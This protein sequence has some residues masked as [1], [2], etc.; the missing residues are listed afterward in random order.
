[1]YCDLNSVDL[2]F[3]RP[4]G[5]ERYVQTDHR[6]PEEIGEKEE[7]SII[8][9][10][11]RML[12][13]RWAAEA[14][15]TLCDVEYHIDCRPPMFLQ[16]AIAAAQG[17][18]YVGPPGKEQLVQLAAVPLGPLLNQAFS[19][20]AHRVC[21]DQK[22]PLSKSGLSQL[23]NT[24]FVL[25]QKNSN[26]IIYWESL[27][28]LAA[29]A[30]EI[31]RLQKQGHWSDGANAETSSFPLRFVV[32]HQDGP[33]YI[34]LLGKAKKFLEYGKDDALVGLVEYVLRA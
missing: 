15:G 2:V 1:M 17:K 12:T 27:I 29:V 11:L 8:F 10:V 18:L 33:A 6:S 32:Y 30:G 9:G 16:Q 3:A 34:N 14:N 4:Q 28:S 23:E 22:C 19:R 24:L 31:I 13:P 25:C 20:L 7:L 26:P 21:S 5:G